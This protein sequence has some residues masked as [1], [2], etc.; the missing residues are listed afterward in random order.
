MNLFTHLSKAL[1]MVVLCSL[2]LPLFSTAQDWILVAND[3]AKDGSNANLA[4]GKKMEF[5]YDGE[6]DEISFRFTLANMSPTIAS[7]FGINAMVHIDESSSQ[8]FKFWGFSN[9][10]DN[11]HY[12]LTAWVTGSAPSNYS[13]TIGIG[14]ASGVSNK[15][16]TNLISNNLQ[17]NLD[18]AAGT[19]T[20]T[21][22]RKDFIPDADLK[23]GKA[24]LRIA[25]AVGSSQGWNDDLYN[26]SRS[27]PFTAKASSVG[28]NQPLASTTLHLYPNPSADRL[29]LSNI[30]QTSKYSIKNQVGQTLLMGSINGG[31]SIDISTLN[32]GIYFLQVEGHNGGVIR[33]N[34]L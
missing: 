19:I 6:K 20:V 14:D 11:F 12:L 29:H 24:N 13:G 16:Y 21:L 5:L 1:V 7:D 3:G 18:E 33:F 23:D 31:S 28:V 32:T 4:D 17:I 25:G 26:A 10:F 8:K 27:I 34:K 30:T 2:A 15:M 9:R 22:D